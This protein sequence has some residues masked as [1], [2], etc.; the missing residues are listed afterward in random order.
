MVFSHLLPSACCVQAWDRAGNKTD[1]RIPSP[2]GGPTVVR[3]SS[4][5]RLVVM[6]HEEKVGSGGDK[7][8]RKGSLS[9]SAGSEG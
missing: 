6:G 4:I 9:R 2:E 3:K 8:V 1:E 7:V 5:K